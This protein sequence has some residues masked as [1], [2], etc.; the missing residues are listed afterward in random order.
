MVVNRELLTDVEQFLYREAQLLDEGRFHEW[1]ELFTEDASY[2]V[3][4]RESVLGGEESIEV[5][6]GMTISHFDDDL[7][8]LRQRVQ[9][10][11]TGFAHT[12]TPPSRTRHLITNVRVD[13]DG[14]EVV[15]HS[16]FLLFQSRREH[17]EF[18]FLGSRVDHLR[19]VGDGWKIARRK[20]VLDHSTLPRAVSVFF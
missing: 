6:D 13:G 18:F 9:R 8:M 10:L 20:V 11:D 7:A 19:K 5:N 14:D 12:E 3:P 17:S 4:I 15:A 16:N 2:W 1:L